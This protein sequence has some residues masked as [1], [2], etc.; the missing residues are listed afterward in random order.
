MNFLL[1]IVDGPNKGAEI[2]LV[3]GVAVTVGKGDDC[4]VVLAD[5]TMDD[6]P[7]R[8]GVSA[9]GVSLDGEPL[10][11][12]LVVV[13]G[14]TAFAVG[15][16]D[17]VWGELKWPE[18]AP[19]QEPKPEAEEKKGPEE[20]REEKK[21]AEAPAAPQPGEDGESKPRRKRGGCCGCLAVLVLAVLAMAGAG[22]FYRAAIRDFCKEKGCDVKIPDV[23]LPALRIPTFDFF[24]SKEPLAL[25]IDV[26]PTLASIAGRYGLA[27][28]ETNGVSKL[29]GNFKTRAERLRAT[30]EAYEAR[31]GVEIDLTDDESFRIAAEDALFTLTEGDL[32]VVA[33]TNRFLTVAGAS[34]SPFAL[35]RVLEA[36]NA[37]IPKLRGVDAGA[38]AFGIAHAA[39]PENAG[40][41]A[42][43][44]AAAPRATRSSQ[45]NPS[46]PALP[47]CGI[48]TA[49]YPC[50]V[51]RDG[52]RVLEGA[53]VGGNTVLKIDADSVTVTNSAGRFTW[54]P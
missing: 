45:K 12:Y 4:D 47:V 1:K 19:D 10:E 31:P 15:P 16:A 14:S 13:R 40:R 41:T 49:P 27:L 42:V 30:A 11:P 2:A 52:T 21:T 32:K 24:S 33:A 28:E 44:P 34:Q 18:K 35:K 29:S 51:L 53:S 37:D 8:I 3:E 46:S 36:V 5:S 38:V 23:K 22:W 9:D 7:V 6:T 43:A 17:A 50:L 20:K 26:R 54:K 25:Q 39:E 48:L